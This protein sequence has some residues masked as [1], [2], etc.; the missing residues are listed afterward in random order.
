MTSKG[1]SVNDRLRGAAAG[2]LLDRAL[3]EPPIEP[4]PLS[5]FGI[6][7][8]RVEQRL[9]ADT[10]AAGSAHALVGTAIGV[11]GGLAVGSTALAT[12][13]AVGGRALGE[14]AQA[15]A[16]ALDTG[17]LD[18]ACSQLKGLVG[19]DT[20]GF[21]VKD[22]SRAVVESVAENTV[23]AIVAPVLWAA[24]AGAPGALAYRAVNTLD[25]MVGYRSPRYENYGWAS[26]RLDD[27]ANWIPA[28]VTAGLVG[29]VRPH[30]A[31]EIWRAVREDAPAHPS[32][33]SGVAEAAF[34]AALGVQLGGENRYAGRVDVRPRLG[35]GRAPERAD[36]DAAIRLSEDVTY[37]LAAALG[38]VSLRRKNRS[39]C[40]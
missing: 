33:N 16:A 9:W 18:Q 25:A 1:P 23:D 13:L 36:I 32:P 38:L 28:R 22:I 30:A 2:A 37:A 17:D 26:A 8:R 31:R 40:R 4:H 21:G 15:V 35:T 24:L 3:G 6:L 7:M 20:E 29:A 34:A 10:R 14:A 27:V 19:R 5:V 12:G 11:I 39:A